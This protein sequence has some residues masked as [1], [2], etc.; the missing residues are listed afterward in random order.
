MIRQ[1]LDTINQLLNYKNGKIKQGLGIDCFLDE[2][3]KFKYKQVNIILGHDN[4]GKTYWINW[5]FLTLALK[6]ELTFCIWSGE[7]DKWQILRNLIQMYSGV[8][9]KDLTEEEIIKYATYL[10]QYF[11][12]VDNSKMYKSKDL[13]KLFDESGCKVGL[14]DPFTGLDREMS[15]SGNYDFMNEVREFVNKT[16]MTIYINT[17]PNTESGRGSNIYTDGEWKGNLKAPLK[18][19]VEGG[20]AFS[21]RCDDFIVIHRLVKDPQMKYST[22]VNVEK[23]KDIET[24]GKHTSL[25]DPVVF[26]FNSGI[27][28]IINQVDPLKPFR[29]KHSNQFPKQPEPIIDK[30]GQSALNWGGGLMSTS[31]KIRLANENPF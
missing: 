4:V 17:H 27:G 20:K 7:N 22:W 3:L 31:E 24:G 16:G 26:N 23:V 6:H 9:F 21:N 1:E 18:D 5:Y 19:H 25:N 2:H 28:F 13:L 8:Q 14:I 12:F 10:E 29:P 15:Y 11:K 30:D